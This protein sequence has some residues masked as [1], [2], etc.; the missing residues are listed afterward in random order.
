MIEAGPE[1]LV[2]LP[3]GGAGE[4]GMNLNLYGHAGRWLMIDCGVSFADDSMAGIDVLTPDP[5]FIAERRDR[6][7]AII[8]THA[9]E[10]HYGAVAHLWPQLQ[11]PVYCTPFTAALLRERL[12]EA[13]LARKVPVKIVRPGERFVVGPFDLEFIQLTHS[14]PEPN[15]VAIRTTAGLAVH[16]GDWKIDADP[17]V[18]DPIDEDRLRALGDEGVRALICDSTNATK[19]SEAGTEGSVGESLSELFARYKKRI[20]VACFASNVARV[21]TLAQVAAQHGRR[22]VLV[23]RSLRRITKAA[24]EVGWLGDDIAFVDDRD[25]RHLRRE[26]TLLICTG[27]QGEPRAALSRIAMEDHPHVALEDGDVAVFSSRIIPGNEKPISRLQDDLARLGVEIVTERDHFIH[28][29]GHPGRN[30]LGKLYEWLRPDVVAP[31]HGEYRHLIAH[32]RFAESHQIRCVIAEDGNALRLA[33]DPF[34][35]VGQTHVG[36]MALLGNRLTPVGGTLWRE[37]GRI[38]RDGAAMITVVLDQEGGLADDAQMSAL[39]L[40]DPDGKD[41]AILDDALDAIESAVLSLPRARRIDDDA[42]VEDAVRRAAR[43]V[44]FER[45]GKKPTTEVHVARV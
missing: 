25:A 2:F 10:D 32:K 24:R 14:I 37:R 9:H 17:V 1:E 21:K 40:L 18:G 31:V 30:E 36:R 12:D 3:L 20:A 44:L 39:G 16:T 38:A 8:L 11:A 13:G 27:S 23:G 42:A 29:S 26:E 6:L 34:E 4:I 7:D 15:A 43:R 5:R 41:D 22:P 28:V 45:V 33:P 35:I 19:D